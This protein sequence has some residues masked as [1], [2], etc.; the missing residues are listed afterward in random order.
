MQFIVIKNKIKHQNNYKKKIY[1]SLGK[2]SMYVVIVK[3][4][5]SLTNISLI[6]GE[7]KVVDK[8]NTLQEEH[9]EGSRLLINLY[10]VFYKKK[11]STS[12]LFFKWIHN[13]NIDSSTFVEL[14][15]LLSEKFSWTNKTNQRL[16]N[17]RYLT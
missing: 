5:F 15:N 16:K 6:Q 11:K 3:I 4:R 2:I 9:L 10:F 12:V 17:K 13:S 8:N 1:W 7:N 14:I